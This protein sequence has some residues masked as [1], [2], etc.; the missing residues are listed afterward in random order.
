[1]KKR[2]A[3][4]NAIKGL[5][6][7]SSML[8]PGVSGGTMALIL[9]IYKDLIHAINNFFKDFKRSFFLLAEFCIGAGLGFLLFARLLDYAMQKFEL[10]LMYFFIGAILG[11][12]PLL[13][14]QSG[15]KKGDLKGLAGC[16]TAL[17]LGAA[18]VLSLGFIPEN[19]FAFGGG[20]SIKS[21]L[22]QLLTGIIIAVALILPGISTS[23][24]LLILGMYQTMLKALENPMGNLVFLGSLA[25]STV[26]GVFLTTNLLE[27]AMN[28]FPQV[29][30]FAIIGFVAGSVIDVFPG[31]PL[32]WEIPVCILTL[33]AGYAAINFMSK[34]SEQKE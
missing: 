2:T 8:I 22:M 30:Y 31:F 6:V 11:G 29:T 24:M 18:I 33:G 3:L 17:L 14:K 13:I 26:I 5:I 9:G 32:G 21:V 10:P 1:M 23:H 4:F 16:G 7:G 19:I 28:K 20:F 12:I 34:F 15:V 25:V 27:K